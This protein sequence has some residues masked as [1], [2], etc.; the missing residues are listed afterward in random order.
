[1]SDAGTEDRAA[2]QEA[3]MEQQRDNWQNTALMYARNSDYWRGRAERA[4]RFYPVAW[5]WAFRRFI[6]NH[7][8]DRVTW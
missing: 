2:P 8:T 7:I 6:R 4:E 1:M 3:S 5:W